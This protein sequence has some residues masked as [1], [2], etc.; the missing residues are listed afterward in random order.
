MNPTRQQMRTPT[1]FHTRD[2]ALRRPLIITVNG[3][4]YGADI[5]YTATIQYIAVRELNAPVLAAGNGLTEAEALGYAL[6]D[7]DNQTP[8]DHTPPYI[9]NPNRPDKVPG[10]GDEPKFDNRLVT[11]QVLLPNSPVTKPDQEE[12]ETT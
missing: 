4:H 12:E 8:Y 1:T 11:N 5:R 3:Y 10:S 2:I 7:L 6:L 9:L